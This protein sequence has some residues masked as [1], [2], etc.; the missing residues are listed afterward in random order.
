MD[1]DRDA[2]MKTEEPETRA[3]GGEEVPREACSSEGSDCGCGAGVCPGMIIGLFLL[4]GW[5]LYKAG[6]WIW[7]IVAG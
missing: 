1:G 2:D 7:G 5:L 4:G 3:T 6:V